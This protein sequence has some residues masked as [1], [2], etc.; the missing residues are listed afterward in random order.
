MHVPD[1]PRPERWLLAC[2]AALLVLFFFVQ[3]AAATPFAQSGDDNAACV[4][5]H[6]SPD[7]K[8]QLPSGEDLSLYVNPDTFAASVHGQQ[9]QRCTDCH[10]NIS[11]FPHPPL[12]A[13]DRRDF[14]L[15]LYTTCRQC[16]M[17]QYQ[18]TLDSVHAYILAGGDRNAPVC[19]DCHGYHDVTPPHQP[20]S[21][22]P[23]TC[24]KCHS[25]IY[26]DY[27]ESVHGA[28]LIEENNRD[29][30]TCIDCH[31]VHTMEDPRTARFRLRSPQICANC[32]TDPVRMD[33]YGISTDVLNT[34]VAD[35]HGATVTLFAKQAPDQPTNKPVCY[36]CHGIHNIKKVTDPEAT[37]VK[38]NLLATCQQCHPD[39]DANFPA[40]WVG[41]YPA[42]PDRHP[43]VYYVQLFYKVLIPGVIGFFVVVIALDATRRTLRRFGR[44]EA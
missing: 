28:A 34:Y 20:R 33:A 10:T 12:F 44:K 36:D 43:I 40:S 22:I 21:R 3:D 35:F 39:A 4:S 41:H 6:S 9:G 38:E 31:G 30:P 29:V 18:D 5:C 23:K 15:G 25:T 37:V 2:T 17:K 11:G 14:S 19:T 7:L 27:Q 8:V 13:R 1:R 42:S 32:H 16:H 26:N 24:A